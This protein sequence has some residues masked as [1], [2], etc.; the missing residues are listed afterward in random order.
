MSGRWAVSSRYRS[1]RQD[2]ADAKTRELWQQ[3]ITNRLK[4]EA[5]QKA[6]E[7]KFTQIQKQE[8]AT[9]EALETAHRQAQERLAQMQAL[10]Q[11]LARDTEKLNVLRKAAEEEVQ[12]IEYS[13]LEAGQQATRDEDRKRATGE[14]YKAGLP[15]P[16]DDKTNAEPTDKK[17]TEP[18]KA[19]PGKNDSG[20]LFPKSGNL[21]LSN[22]E[23][24]DEA[25]RTWQAAHK[26]SQRSHGTVEA[27]EEAQAREQYF[28]FKALVPIAFSCFIGF[29]R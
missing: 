28:R 10:R 17:P 11:S 26:K 21:F 8:K 1:A 20:S 12:R 18:A 7:E 22:D 6:I 19:A 4:L 15:M 27:A 9:M 2:R 23:L 29:A 14:L 16:A 3:Q 13:V 25:R 24:L 5:M